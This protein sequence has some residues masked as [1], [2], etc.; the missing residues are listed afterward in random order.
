MLTAASMLVYGAA[1]SLGNIAGGILIVGVGYW[2]AYG[3]EA[4][5]HETEV[6]KLAE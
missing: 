6:E 1:A 3:R 2:I 5:K 4:H